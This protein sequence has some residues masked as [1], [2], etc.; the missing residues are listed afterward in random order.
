M[1]PDARIATAAELLDS[2]LDGQPAEQVLTGW[3]RRSRFAGSKDRAAI[4]DHV[5]DALR[6]R[7]SYALLGGGMTGRGLMFGQLLA[8]GRAP[9]EAFTGQGHAPE[10]LTEDETAALRRDVEAALAEAPAP[11]AGDM[12][13]WIWPLLTEALGADAAGA[14][15][16]LR[17]RAPVFL[18]VN[19][20]RGDLE[21][22]RASLLRDGIETQE[23]PLSPTALEVTSGARQVA[24]STAYE[25]GLVELQDAASQALS[26]ALPLRNGM[27]ILDYCA[28][29]GG[30][31]LAMAA[32][33]QARITAHDANPGRLSDLPAR[34]ARA[35]V[36]VAI[37]RQP[38]GPFD[39][40]LCD[41][42]CS[43]SG[44]WR[45]SP[46]GK[47]ALTTDA[48]TELNQ[49]QDDILQKAAA[50]TAQDGV[51]AYA[52]CSLFRAENEDRIAKFLSETKG[53]VLDFERRWLPQMGGDGFY[54]ACLR[55]G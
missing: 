45:R 44:A 42:P 54:L 37:A 22:A 12:P 33:V 11:V 25:T 10:Q 18:R 36:D 47:W 40:V 34:A 7:R 27:T 43:G 8:Q 41:V 32:H 4:R 21:T 15:A 1:T 17:Q 20:A 38:K 31:T 55:R 46:E 3:A 24:R 2:I 13:D 30:K 53:W 29:G 48:L 26:D 9:E 5:F 35:G 6:C 51:L 52:T 28:G 23:H 14:A 16:L 50:L 39:L 49:T 19:T